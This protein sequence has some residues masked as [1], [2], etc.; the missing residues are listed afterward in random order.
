MKKVERKLATLINRMNKV[1]EE[2]D[3]LKSE[4][5][6]KIWEI[7]NNEDCEINDNK[8]DKLNE[9]VEYIDEVYES[10]NTAIAEL[11]NYIEY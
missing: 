10:L 8:L 7:E 5:E 9:N 4:L 1:Q 11:E 3:E 2:L 6:D